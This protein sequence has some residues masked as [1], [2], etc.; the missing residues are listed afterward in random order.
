MQG[1]LQECSCFPVSDVASD[2]PDIV[3]PH[4]AAAS[5]ASATSAASAV[6]VTYD[7]LSLGV[8]NK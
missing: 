2:A 6:I 5:A 8:H 3:R 1:G 7:S 4:A